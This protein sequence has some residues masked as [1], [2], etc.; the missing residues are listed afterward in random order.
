MRRIVQSR[1]RGWSTDR[2][3][4][5]ALA[6]G[7][8]PR[9]RAA[10][11]LLQGRGT[12]EMLARIEA[13]VHSTSVRRRVLG[14]DIAAQLRAPGHSHDYEAEPYALETTQAL[15]VDALRDRDPRVVRAAIGGLGHRP[16]AA[17]LPALLAQLE[18]PDLRV[19]FS[20][21]YTLGSYPGPEGTGALM[22]LA[23]DRDDL[24][25]EWATFGIGTLS[26][27]DNDAIRA[28]LWTNAHD[29]Y[30]DVRG[31]AVVGLARR[32]DSRVIEL[33]KTRLL[34]DDCRVYELEAAEEMPSAELLE[35]LQRLRDD[36]EQRHDLDPFW[37]RHLL[38]AIDACA[39]VADAT[40]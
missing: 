37:H 16:L 4:H 21:A 17:A 6:H 7:A 2:L 28:L 30:R 33:L 38:E 8:A 10:I 3:I 29:P 13:L 34:E 24:V 20:L 27:A 1:I 14:L 31:E 26:E 15:F 9:G 40:P 12:P 39:L 32:S 35:P 25:R 18:H 11:A 19:R 23:I 22:R 5:L 36:A